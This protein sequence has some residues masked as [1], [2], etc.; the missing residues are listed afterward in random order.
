M[1]NTP[2]LDWI[3]AEGQCPSGQCLVIYYEPF[4]GG[5]TPEIGI[6]YF[7][8]PKDYEDEDGQGWLLWLN[9]RPI[10]VSHFVPI[11]KSP[12]KLINS[13]QEDFINKV[14]RR[15]DLGIVPQDMLTDNV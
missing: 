1:N 6:G 12:Y 14:G 8:N 10:N 13:M 7:D 11:D 3:P 5:L 9:D 15:P 2:K 4:F